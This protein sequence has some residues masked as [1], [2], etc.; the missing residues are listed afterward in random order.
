MIKRG[1][2][3]GF[4]GTQNGMTNHQQ[5]HVHRI[6]R[7]HIPLEYNEKKN[8]YFHHG[9]CVGSDEEAA[10]IARDLGYTIVCHPPIDPKKRAYFPSDEYRE[11][12]PYLERNHDIVDE[13]A[14]MLATPN[15]ATEQLRSG[16]WATVRYARKS[17]C[18]LE[19]IQ[20]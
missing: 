6:L 15:E 4:T 20:P 9:D 18:K 3:I 17:G 8:H 2:H 12:K 5:Y 16:T 14:I 11:E 19:V 1:K 13:S 7:E 10:K